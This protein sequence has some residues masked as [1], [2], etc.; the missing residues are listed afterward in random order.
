MVAIGDK[1]D[2][3][4]SCRDVRYDPKRAFSIAR[5]FKVSNYLAGRLNPVK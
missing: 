2:M 5:V 1:A 4:P 3:A